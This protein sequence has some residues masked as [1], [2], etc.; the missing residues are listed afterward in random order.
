LGIID[1]P[2]GPT[3]SMP[4]IA[5]AR[6]RQ[7]RCVE[8]EG[9]A[10]YAVARSSPRPAGDPQRDGWTQRADQAGAKEVVVHAAKALGG[11]M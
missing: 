1:E 11:G 10:V 3:A 2:D 4:T 5:P 9:R 6:E 8:N 7:Q